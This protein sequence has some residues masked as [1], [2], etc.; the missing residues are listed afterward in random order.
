M[1]MSSVP[2]AF[3]PQTACA[4]GISV[5]HQCPPRRKHPQ[6]RGRASC[7]EHARG[8]FSNAGL[9]CSRRARC[10]MI[11]S[12][13]SSSL[14]LG[15]LRKRTF[16]H[17]CFPRAPGRARPRHAAEHDFEVIDQ[18]DVYDALRQ[19]AGT[20]HAADI[21]RDCWRRGDSDARHIYSVFPFE[22][23][24]F[25]KLAIKYLTEAKSLVVSAPTGSGKTVVGEGAI[26]L[27][28]ASGMRVFYT[29]P[30]KALSNQ[31]FFD[32]Q[33]QYGED[34]VG[35]LTGDTTVN[36]EAQVIVMT[37][38]IYRNMLYAAESGDMV[39]GIQ[40]A[41]GVVDDVFAVVFDEF[42]YMNDKERG[43]VWEE[44]VIISP[45]HI[46]LVALSATISNTMEVK[47]W[48][49]QVHGPTEL[50][51][52]DFRP[53]PLNFGFARRRGLD[54]LFEKGEKDGGGRLRGSGG[55]RSR[56]LLHSRLMDD[57]QIASIMSSDLKMLDKASKLRVNE[58]GRRSSGGGRGSRGS[59]TDVIQNLDII[60]GG[61][62]PGVRR[63][64]YAE[65]PSIPY[66]VRALQRKDLLPAIVFIFSRDG[67]DRAAMEVLTENDLLITPS[68]QRVL[69]DRVDE[70]LNVHPSL[71]NEDRITLARAGIA[72]HHAGMLPIWKSFVERLFQEGLIKVVFATETLAAG[73]NMPARTTVISSM[74]KRAGD[75][76]HVLLTTSQVLQ[77][78][79]RA[80]RRGKDVIGH[81]IF[82]RTAFEG[83]LHAYYLLTKGVDAIQSTF[84]P[85]YGMVLNLLKRRTLEESRR[86]LEKSFG[87]FLAST[88]S[89]EKTKKQLKRQ[90]I[91]ETFRKAKELLQT[92]SSS[93]LVRYQKKREQ[94]KAEIRNLEYMKSG[95]EKVRQLDIE[96]DL[97]FAP[98]GSLLRLESLPSRPRLPSKQSRTEALDYYVDVEDLELEAALE[99]GLGQSERRS[100]VSGIFLGPYPRQIAQV[101][102][103]AVIGG[104]GNFHFVTAQHV[105][106]INPN[107]DDAVSSIFFEN[108]GALANFPD[109]SVWSRAGRK[110]FRA[111][112]T[113]TAKELAQHIHSVDAE[114]E[115]GKTDYD[116]KLAIEDQ[117]ER[118]GRLLAELRGM[119]EVHDRP[120]R[121][122]LIKAGR[123]YAALYDKYGMAA[124]AEA[125]GSNEG[126]WR[127]FMSVVSVLQEFGY[128]DDQ[129]KVTRLGHL[130]AAVRAENEVWMSTV[131]TAEEIQA[132]QPQQ[133]AAVIAAVVV[134]SRIRPDVFVDFELSEDVDQACNSLLYL[135][136]RIM[137]SQEDRGLGF[138]AGVDKLEAALAENWAMGMSWVEFMS[139]TSLQEG[140]VCRK[141]RRTMDALRQ[142]PHLPIVSESLRVAARRA[143][144][145]MDRFPVSD[146][147]TYKVDDQ[148][149]ARGET[150]ESLRAS[151]RRNRT[152]VGNVDGDT[153]VDVVEEDAFGTYNDEDA[154][155]VGQDNF[156]DS[157]SGDEDDNGDI[158]DSDENQSES[159]FSMDQDTLFG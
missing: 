9:K 2:A 77:M 118:V 65:V 36:R 60:L 140:D 7:A 22:L 107:V 20:P 153:E 152:D 4:N 147:V 142:I 68:E 3:H 61:D 37:T 151:L 21:L 8:L 58:R 145:L 55:L 66:V 80:G 146:E 73:I 87:H 157:A 57:P 35:L 5:K 72:S 74:S 12:P 67:C 84:T 64:N 130:G 43:T 14:W 47:D 29:T 10:A 156:F 92:V 24:E 126:S 93:N 52:S 19:V 32:F 132:L 139:R 138:S 103:F 53:V 122:E 39:G 95:L 120:D 105:T 76:G 129:F 56:P 63:T 75:A 16:D 91:L 18:A 106:F 81:S 158:D 97:P 96:R 62:I 133:L 50:I 113:P 71:V 98:R 111:E 30:L 143:L 86:L 83:P 31:K 34:R 88:A 42:H 51:V 154:M 121:L 123:A 128:L 137:L 125:N 70:F 150:P 144:T 119:S 85:S 110:R 108:G 104:D 46:L 41:M 23:D 69:R 135:N 94:L 117:A 159:G 59:F 100:C 33:A 78:A 44:S 116:M 114:A 48:F 13:G 115:Y 54:P 49:A 102:Y 25:Q 15:G 109:P 101:P 148:D 17:E 89:S 124:E 141:L 11:A 40:G 155:V 149:K 28:L 134:D 136:D 127:D 45:P 27:A 1:V 26:W 131:L 99:H 82:V 6:P 79:G 90:R 112:G 38:E